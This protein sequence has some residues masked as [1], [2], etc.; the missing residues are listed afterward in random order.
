MFF[1]F[2]SV[3]S[4]NATC[5]SEWAIFVFFHTGSTLFFLLLEDILNFFM[6]GNIL[7]YRPNSI[8]IL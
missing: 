7:C 1:S 6:V 4:L 2:F 5:L 8:G 3:F